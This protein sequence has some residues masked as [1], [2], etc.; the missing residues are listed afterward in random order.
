MFDCF[1][2]RF[3][4]AVLELYIDG[5]QAVCIR[6]ALS[7]LLNIMFR[8]LVHV[9]YIRSEVRSIPLN[10]YTPVSRLGFSSV[11]AIMNKISM[12]IC[13]QVF[14]CTCVLSFSVNTW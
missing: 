9:E 6:L 5:N 8:I 7:L 12:S 2:H 13:L 1:D 10:E 3:N 14:V 11:W 4:V